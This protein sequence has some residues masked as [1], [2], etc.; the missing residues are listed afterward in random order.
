LL[1]GLG[2]PATF[3]P[4]RMELVGSIVYRESNRLRIA[5]PYLAPTV[6]DG[7][8]TKFGTGQVAE[9]FIAGFL[10]GARTDE[11]VGRDTRI[12][13]ARLD[14]PCWAITRG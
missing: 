2:D 12:V 4:P 6:I 3:T 14:V 13:S 5:H 8:V 11:E 10:R 1:I 7:G 9:S